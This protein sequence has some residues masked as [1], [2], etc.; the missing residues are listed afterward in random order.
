[1]DQHER[2]GHR[3]NARGNISDGR[4]VC[5]REWKELTPGAGTAKLRD[6]GGKLVVTVQSSRALHRPPTQS[7]PRFCV[8][9]VTLQVVTF[10]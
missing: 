3:S 9:E 10:G 1:V 7:F 4:A 2:I 5:F 8:Y 6:T